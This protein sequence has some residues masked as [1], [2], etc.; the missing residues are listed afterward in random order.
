SGH[1]GRQSARRAPPRTELGRWDQGRPTSPRNAILWSRCRDVNIGLGIVLDATKR[2][3]G[4][5]VSARAAPPWP[6]AAR[7]PRFRVQGDRRGTTASRLVTDALTFRAKSQVVYA[8][9]AH[10]PHGVTGDG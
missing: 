7:R 3:P 8:H 10:T 4:E 2:S 5:R 6:C 1:R 9:L